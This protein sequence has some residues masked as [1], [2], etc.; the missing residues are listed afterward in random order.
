VWLTN[1]DDVTIS[2]EAIHSDLPDFRCHSTQGLQV[3]VA[4][5]ALTHVHLG[6]GIQPAQ[7]ES[8][9]EHAEFDAIPGW[10][11]KLFEK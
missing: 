7:L 6:D 10:E 5:L 9:D 3:L 2:I 1:R 11:G 8:V 4:M